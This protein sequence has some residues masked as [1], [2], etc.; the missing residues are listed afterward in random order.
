M[1]RPALIAAA[2]IIVLIVAGVWYFRGAEEP[3]VEEPA[4]VVEALTPPLPIEEPAPPPLPAL[5]G[6]DDMVRR[7]ATV[8]GLAPML[9]KALEDADV[10][11]RFVAVV[12][13]VASG[14]SPGRHLSF[15]APEQPFDA[16]YRDDT[17]Y[18]DPVSYRRYDPVGEALAGLDV[19]AAVS[20]F[21]RV[22]PLADAAYA[23]L[24]GEERPFEPR[25]RQALG[26]L[27]TTPVVNDP[28]ELVDAIGRLTYRDEALERLSLPQKHLLRMGPQSVGRIQAKLR[29]ILDQLAES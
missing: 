1:Q 29:E 16:L 25:L 3:P 8:L 12:D 22:E 20:V 21:R 13:A 26:V 28:P 11:R 7:A 24:I 9:A 23:E 19:S 5:D 15:L 27:L 17:W 4:A 6:S 10:M 2:V 14:E 18:M